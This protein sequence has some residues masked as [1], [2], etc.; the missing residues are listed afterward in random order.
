MF[1]LPIFTAGAIYRHA[2]C[3]SPVGSEPTAASGGG[4]EREWQRS[5]NSRASVS[6]QN[7]SGTA[8]GLF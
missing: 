2:V 7:F 4:K 6:P 8:T 1:A 3:N 5:K